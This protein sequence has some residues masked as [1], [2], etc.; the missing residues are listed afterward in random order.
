MSA[1]VADVHK[2]IS[3]GRGLLLSAA[4]LAATGSEA[5][6]AMAK[7]V[8][9]LGAALLAKK[10]R[11]KWEAQQLL[12]LGAKAARSPRVPPAIGLGIKRKQEE[13]EERQ[14]QEGIAAG[15]VRVKG[16][17]ATKRRKVQQRS[18]TAAHRGG[19]GNLGALE[20]VLRG[21]VLHVQPLPKT[22]TAQHTGGSRQQKR[23]GSRKQREDHGGFSGAATDSRGRR[24]GKKGGGRGKGNKSKGARKKRRK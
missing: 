5:F 3:G 18:A 15:M 14:R 10:D 22:V 21:G 2:P 9:T 13:R 4:G 17:G 1:R 12:E 7:E 23:G 20:D 6:R 11:A 8:E 19:P 16:S 24:Q